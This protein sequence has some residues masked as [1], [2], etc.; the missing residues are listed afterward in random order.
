MCVG[1]GGGGGGERGSKKDRQPL[2]C[3]SSNLRER[4]TDY[5]SPPRERERE[6][7][8]LSNLRER[9]TKTTT[10]HRKRERERGV[11]ERQTILQMLLV[12]LI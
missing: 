12:S 2:K 7:C 4:Q 9:Q 10:V 5:D 6:S 11:K 3:S 1:G 8:S